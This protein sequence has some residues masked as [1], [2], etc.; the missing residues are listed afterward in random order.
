MVKVKQHISKSKKGKIFN[1]KDYQKNSP[2]NKKILSEANNINNIDEFKKDIKLRIAKFEIKRFRNKNKSIDPSKIKTKVERRISYLYPEL[3]KLKNNKTKYKF[4]FGNGKIDGVIK[5]VKNLNPGDIFYNQNISSD[6]KWK[7]TIERQNLKI[8]KINK[9]N[10]INN[11]QNINVSFFKV[12]NGKIV[13]YKDKDF[14]I[15]SFYNYLKG[16]M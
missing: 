10:T 13:N 4:Y 15:K 7:Q 11:K 6:K 1:V 14:N 5:N 3:D 9:I 2:F 8:L 12:K 16:E